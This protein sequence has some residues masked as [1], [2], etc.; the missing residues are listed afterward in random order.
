MAAPDATMKGISIDTRVEAQ[1]KR[2]V[3]NGAGEAQCQI[4]ALLVRKVYVYVCGQ[5]CWLVDPRAHLLLREQRA[6][7]THHAR[8]PAV[9]GRLATYH[10][11]LAKVPPLIEINES[12]HPMNDNHS[13]R[14][15]VA[16]SY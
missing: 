9:A 7:I 15:A 2:L 11:S 13:S 6:P 10:F 3:K 5:M 16:F 4:G 1:L 8:L 14:T 12:H